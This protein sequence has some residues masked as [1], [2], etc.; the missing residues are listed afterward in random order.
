VPCNS[1]WPRWIARRV[2]CAKVPLSSRAEATVR[3]ARMAEATARHKP[4]SRPVIQIFAA[5]AHRLRGRRV[6]LPK[7]PLDPVGIRA[8]YSCAVLGAHQ[9]VESEGPRAGALCDFLQDELGITRWPLEAGPGATLDQERSRL[10]RHVATAESSTRS[11]PWPNSR[12]H[13]PRPDANAARKP[14]S[15]MYSSASGTLSRPGSQPFGTTWAKAMEKAPIRPTSSMLASR[16]PGGAR[17]LALS[18]R[19]RAWRR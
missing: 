2:C 1:A 7:P 5:P 10:R 4:P 11:K 3:R 15:W 12:T 6:M 18:G 9:H 17:S 19:A 8:R 13:V 16:I 14:A